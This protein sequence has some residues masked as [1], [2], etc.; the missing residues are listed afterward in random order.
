MNKFQKL[1]LFCEERQCRQL[2]LMSKTFEKERKKVVKHL[3]ELH[4]KLEKS[5]EENSFLK[6]DMAQRTSQ[7]QAIQEE[8]LEKAIQ[9]TNM[10]REVS[11]NKE[12]CCLRQK[13]V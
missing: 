12:T 8:L 13:L 1:C 5:E 4:A 3:K 2:E 9:S 7:F 10:E 6:A 11:R